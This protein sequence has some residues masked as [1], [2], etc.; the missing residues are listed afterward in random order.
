[1]KRTILGITMSFLIVAGSAAADMGDWALY[2]DFGGST[3]D[4]TKWY[5]GDPNL[6]ADVVNN[7]ARLSIIQSGDEDTDPGMNMTNCGG[8]Y[9]VKADMKLLSTSTDDPDDDRVM[10]V[11]M[12]VAINSPD[13]VNSGYDAIFGLTMGPEEG[14]ARIYYEVENANTGD[15][16]IRGIDY[17]GA[18]DTYYTFAITVAPDCIDFYFNG[19]LVDN[20]TGQESIL[21]AGNYSLT[22][23]G[24]ESRTYNDG[25][26]VDARVDNVYVAVPEPLSLTALSAGAMLFAARRRRKTAY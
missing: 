7:E 1:M 24:F 23:V 17:D 22:G 19:S 14:D 20:Y 10:Q 9:G 21:E 6:L 18:L 26:F 5:K 13:G 3:L 16:W 8:V 11:K 2:D 4:M 25:E 12:M 15:R